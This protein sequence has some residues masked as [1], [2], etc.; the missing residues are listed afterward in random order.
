MY[1]QQIFVRRLIFINAFNVGDC[2]ICFIPYIITRCLYR[3]TALAV[4][5]V[6]SLN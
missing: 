1:F 4:L 6:L 5:S 3:C 2:A